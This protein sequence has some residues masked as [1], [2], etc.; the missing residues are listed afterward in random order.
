MSILGQ[1]TDLQ[2][3]HSLNEVWYDVAVAQAMLWVA[4]LNEW[5]YES[6]G[7]ALEGRFLRNHAS[8]LC[9][10]SNQI[11]LRAMGFQSKPCM[12]I[13]VLETDPVPRD[14]NQ[15]SIS[16]LL[17]FAFWIFSSFYLCILGKIQINK[18]IVVISA[19]DLSEINFADCQLFL[20]MVLHILSLSCFTVSKRPRNW[21]YL[22]P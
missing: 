14:E 3:S 17:L 8:F 4:T 15:T 9:L 21:A 2:M 16:P 11:V 1:Q 19:G 20:L 5:W 6:P 22:L 10:E 12:S 7:C 18:V 13:G